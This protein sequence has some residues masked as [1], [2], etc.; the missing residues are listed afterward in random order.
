[1]EFASYQVIAIFNNV[2]EDF[3]VSHHITR[4]KKNGQLRD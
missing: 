4:G 2:L 3:L 1:M